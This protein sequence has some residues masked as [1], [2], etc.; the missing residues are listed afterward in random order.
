MN[1]PLKSFFF[2]SLLACLV[3]LSSCSSS[4]DGPVL[5]ELELDTRNPSVREIAP[6]DLASSIVPANIDFKVNYDELVDP[7][8]VIENVSLIALKSRRIYE[9]SVIGSKDYDPIPRDGRSI[10]I[11]QSQEIFTETRTEVLN[12]TVDEDGVVER[13]TRI[14]TEEVVATSL[15]I[16]PSERLALST[17]YQLSLGE[18]IKDSSPVASISPIDGLSTTGNF[19]IPATYEFGTSDGSWRQGMTVNDSFLIDGFN[20]VGVDYVSVE[21]AGHALWMQQKAS[22]GAFSHLYARQFDQ[23]RQ[24][25][26]SDGAERVDYISSLDG[27]LAQDQ[28]VIDFA[29]GGSDKSYCYAWVAKEALS[30]QSVFFRCGIDDQLFERINVSAHSDALAISDL[31]ISHD[32]DEGGFISYR[33]DSQLYVYAFS[34]PSAGVPTVVASATIGAGIAVTEVTTQ[35]QE[36]ADGFVLNALLAVSDTSQPSSLRYSLNHAII[37]R[38]GSGLV[39]SS[40]LIQS[41]S[42]P[43]ESLSVGFDFLGR[44]LA[45]WLIGS[46]SERVFL[47]SRYSGSSWA[48]PIPVLKSG[49]GWVFD[50]RV[51]VFE[52]GQSLYAWAENLGASYSLNVQG[53][54]PDDG[55]AR[56]VRPPVSNLVS[57]STDL[58]SVQVIG[59]REGNAF[60]VYN[61]GSRNYAIR[62]QQNVSWGQAWGDSVD[63]GPHSNSPVVIRPVRRDGRMAVIDMHARTGY[64]SVV[65]RLFSDV[66]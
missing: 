13:E 65:M 2:I 1:P 3:L 11:G 47:T 20:V 62:F 21:A 34:A 53:L 60:V 26:S 37:S 46:G 61:Q 14:I 19:A 12:E 28:E 51:F 44:G 41:A 8:S 25:F 63:V 43:Y 59:D 5:A 18:G 64:D 17:F 52:D 16:V 9:T 35:L 48:Q 58:S 56:F 39:T 10:Y 42:E 45:G 29:S 6:R 33:F 50:G 24:A 7:L 30:I 55:G 40:K 54:F 49:S 4:N 15:Q 22:P 27:V 36:T 38:S 66:D 23:G 57:T 32:D 31:S